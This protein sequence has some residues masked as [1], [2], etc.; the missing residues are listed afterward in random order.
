MHVVGRESLELFCAA[1]ADVRTQ[2]D[3]WLADVESASWATPHELKAHYPHAS[4]L[5]RNLVVFNIKG[6][7]YRL[8]AK[9]NYTSQVVLVK[10]IGTHADY[11]RWQL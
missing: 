9:I 8:A 10:Q 4:L 7:K 1:H 3:A 6:N 5:G 11:D 2:V